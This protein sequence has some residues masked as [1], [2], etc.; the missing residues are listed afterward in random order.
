MVVMMM[1]VEG[2]IVSWHV[3]QQRRPIHLWEEERGG[4][5]ARQEIDG[6]EAAAGCAGTEQAQRLANLQSSSSGWTGDNERRGRTI[7]QTTGIRKGYI[8]PGWRRQVGRTQRQTACGDVVDNID[9]VQCFP[10]V[11]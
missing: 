9:V 1:V 6:E 7:R 4:G 11:K 8:S 2:H 10:N 3:Y 5:Q